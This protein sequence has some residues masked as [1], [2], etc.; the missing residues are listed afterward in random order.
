MYGIATKWFDSNFG[1]T[2]TCSAD[3]ATAARLA[4]QVPRGYKV[5]AHTRSVQYNSTL[6]LSWTWRAGAPEA[7]LNLTGVHAHMHD[8]QSYFTGS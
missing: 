5:H 4:M 2:D 3:T 7:A 8:Q 1:T 6:V